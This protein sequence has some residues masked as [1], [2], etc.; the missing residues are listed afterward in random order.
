[1]RKIFSAYFINTTHINIIEIIDY[2][3]LCKCIRDEA[4]VVLPRGDDKE[5]IAAIK[6]YME[7]TL[8]QAFLEKLAEYI[9]E[10]VSAAIQN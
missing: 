3:H 7:G 4:F 10:D 6:K 1:M 8:E 5:L 2:F 9:G